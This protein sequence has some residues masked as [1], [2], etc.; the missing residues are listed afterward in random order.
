M[1]TAQ[2]QRR[3]EAQAPPRAADQRAEAG[4]PRWREPL[5]EGRE[6]KRMLEG[7]GVRTGEQVAIAGGA[8]VEVGLVGQRQ[9]REGRT[10]CRGAA[11]RRGSVEGVGIGHAADLAYHP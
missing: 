7:R 4:R 3:D 9:R 11:R 6:P 2:D 8:H 5:R 10:A 1:A